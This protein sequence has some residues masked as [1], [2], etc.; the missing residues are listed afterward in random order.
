MTE[1]QQDG[2]GQ[3]LAQ[4]IADSQA[5]QGRATVF[6]MVRSMETEFAKAL[7]K[8]MPLETFMRTA[9]TELRQTPQ[10][11]MCTVDSLLGA[12]MTAAR[13]GL[14]VGGPMG[15]FYLTPRTVKNKSTGQHE[16]QVVPIIGYKGLIEL[17]TRSGKVGRIDADLVREGDTFRMGYD[18][19]RGGKFVLHEMLDY[20][21][22]RPIVGVLAWADVG[23]GQL[24]RYLPMSAV[25]GR[26][27][28]GSAGDS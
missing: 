1:Q 22:T 19:T 21:E 16:K 24:A 9:V 11:Q 13:L 28:R 26:K 5:K 18:S 3:A 6:D 20:E 2:T 10:L 12:F 15:Q 23:G 17:A 4:T 8:H 27:D 7:P 25:E 14:E